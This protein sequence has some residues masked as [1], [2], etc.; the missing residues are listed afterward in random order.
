MDRCAACG[1]TLYGDAAW[2]GQCLAPVRTA[3]PNPFAA[4]VPEPMRVGAAV[5]EAGVPAPRPMAAPAAPWARPPEPAWTPPAPVAKPSWTTSNEV[6]VAVPLIGILLLGALV[7]VGLWAYAKDGTHQAAHLIRLS[8]WVILGFYGVVLAMVVRMA[9]RVDFLPLWSAGPT[10]ENVAIGALKGVAT[11]TL[12]LLALSGATGRIQVAP[13]VKFQLGDATLMS[14]ALALLL[15]TVAAPVVEELLFRGMVAEAL[16]RHGQIVALAVSGF[17]FALW[18]M[19]FG[20]VQLLYYTV[21]GV[22]LGRTYWKRGLAASIA[23]HA[24]FNGTLAVV[25]LVFIVGPGGTIAANGVSVQAPGGWDEIE[26]A[27]T[28]LAPAAL[29]AHG[30]SS[31]VFYVMRMPLPAGV[32]VQAAATALQQN[33]PGAGPATTVRTTHYPAGQAVRA[34]VTMKGNNG[35]VAL[36]S[37]PSGWWMAVLEQSTDRSRGDF[38]EMLESLD[39]S[40]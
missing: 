3:A 25:A 36:I 19:R 40:D 39:L 23:T 1:A 37:T 38:E 26:T 8:Q 33:L 32:P 30:P 6:R 31:A 2:C 24:G 22:M 29:A 20:A 12:V 7:Q 4:R 11:A 10:A 15:L 17:L 5:L 27:G 13:S 34:S 16:R 28:P 21:L 9:R 18:H 35:E 14:A